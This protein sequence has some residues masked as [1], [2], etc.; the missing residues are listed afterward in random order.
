MTIYI[1]ALGVGSAWTVF[2]YTS[3]VEYWEILQKTINTRP[4]SI[5]DI[6]DMG[7]QVMGVS[8]FIIL[9]PCGA[10]GFALLV[11]IPPLGPAIPIVRVIRSGRRAILS[12]VGHL[13]LS[14][15]PNPTSRIALFLQRI[16]G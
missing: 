13:P 2:C 3:L 8:V 14:I 4:M 16:C 10:L 11:A 6:F 1:F 12:H 5:D 15:R 7:M 9:I